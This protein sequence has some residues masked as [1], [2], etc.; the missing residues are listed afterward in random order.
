[1]LTG[2]YEN[3]IDAKGRLVVPAVFREQ[4][5]GE[6]VLTHSDTRCLRIYSKEEFESLYERIAAA[7]KEGKPGVRGLITLFVSPAR[8]LQCDSQG[9]LSVPIEM[10]TRIGLD[11]DAVTVGCIDHVEIW[12][13]EE[14]S[15]MEDSLGGEDVQEAIDYVGAR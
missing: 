13:K 1:M 5:G 4:L 2:Y 15:R 8:T 14:Y 6:L 11:R 12:D 10:R 7:K 9:R 3:S